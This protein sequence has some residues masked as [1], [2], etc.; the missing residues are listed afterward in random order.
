MFSACLIPGCSTLT[1]GGT[2]VEHDPPAS[3][4]FPPG[5][6]TCR[7]A[8]R[9]HPLSPRPSCRK[10]RVVF[11]TG[12]PLSPPLLLELADLLEDEPLAAQLRDAHRRR[13][14]A[15]ALEPEEAEAILSVLDDPPPRL[16][17][18]RAVLFREIEP[19][20]AQGL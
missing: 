1:M 18:L 5:T 19:R 3:V 10:H 8:S 12:V 9:L 7:C 20:R 16:K 17:E 2:C 14:I 11:L 13:L 6:T 15:F 4:T